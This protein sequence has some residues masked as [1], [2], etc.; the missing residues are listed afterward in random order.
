[1]R[2]KDLTGAIHDFSYAV[3]LDH[4]MVQYRENL[5]VAL[6]EAGEPVEALVELTKAVEMNPQSDLAF[7]HRGLA[8]SRLEGT[9]EPL[10]ISRRPLLL[11]MPM[12]PFM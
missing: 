11:I 1:M 10:K 9:I 3:K 5:G 8:N 4:E 7:N 6:M 2:V 12:R